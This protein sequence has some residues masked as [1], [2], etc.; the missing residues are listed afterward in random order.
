MSDGRTCDCGSISSMVVR[1]HAP[2]CLMQPPEIRQPALQAL[3]M[4]LCGK[5]GAPV[6]PENVGFH[7]CLRATRYDHVFQ[8]ASGSREMVEAPEGE[9]VRYEDVEGDVERLHRGMLGIH[10]AGTEMAEL[11]A[12]A[13]E[14]HQRALLK[15]RL[16]L[17]LSLHSD[18]DLLEVIKKL[19]GR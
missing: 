3:E 6:H 16:A 14:S 10:S 2:W 19:M 17:G 12:V 15:I 8:K 13:L 1:D 18:D 7:V 9:W 11:H 4:R 5:C